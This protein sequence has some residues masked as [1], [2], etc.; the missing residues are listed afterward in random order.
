MAANQVTSGSLLSWNTVPAV[1]R[2]C[3]LQRLH[4]NSS[5]ALSSQKPRPPQAGQVRPS[6]QRISNK[7][8]RQASSVPKRSRNPASLRPLTERRSP[9]ADAIRR[10]RQPRK[11]RKP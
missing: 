11:L 3:F 1:S 7:A 2:S 6:G 8:P 9:S 4:W 5:R 10:L